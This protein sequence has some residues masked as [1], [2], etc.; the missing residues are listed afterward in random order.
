MGGVINGV[1]LHHTSVDFITTSSTT[2]TDRA[3]D[4]EEYLQQA[5]DIL[6]HIHDGDAGRFV[7]CIITNN[8]STG[9]LNPLHHI[10]IRPGGQLF[11]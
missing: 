11:G 6:D 7:P 10:S 3:R 1:S 2:T 8:D 4:D 9:S 5:N